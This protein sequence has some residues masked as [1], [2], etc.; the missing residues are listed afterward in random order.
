MAFGS[1]AIIH[2]NVIKSSITALLPS[3]E[4]NS[5]EMAISLD[6]AEEKHEQTI[7]CIAAYQQ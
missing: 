2:P 6:L 7:T 5:K 4:Q 3:I 1:E